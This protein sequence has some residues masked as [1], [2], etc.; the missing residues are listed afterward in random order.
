MV[1]CTL[2]AAAV[3]SCRVK[4]GRWIAPHLAVGAHFDCVR[5]SQSVKVQTVW[6]D[7]PQFMARSDALVLD[8]SLWANDVSLAWLDWSGAAETALADAYRF[9]G[10]PFWWRALL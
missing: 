4:P 1:G 7:R 9:A 6:D 5:G 8:E 3:S 10:A 2:A